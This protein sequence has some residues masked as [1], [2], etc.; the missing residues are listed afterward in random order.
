[1][2][3]PCVVVFFWNGPCVNIVDMICNVE[4]KFKLTREVSQ[5]ENF[6]DEVDRVENNCGCD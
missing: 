4:N 6:V 1:M 3:E 5:M 2:F